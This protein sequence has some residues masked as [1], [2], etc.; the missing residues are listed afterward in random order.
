M[1]TNLLTFR[2]TGFADWESEDWRWAISSRPVNYPDT[3]ERTFSVRD[4]T[5]MEWV[6]DDFPT[7]E[8]AVAYCEGVH[9]ADLREL[10]IEA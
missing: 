1:T 5:T 6:E 2:P 7:Y 3:G 4:H 10:G 8:A 9:R